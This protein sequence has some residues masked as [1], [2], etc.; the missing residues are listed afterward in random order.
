MV[1]LE[2]RSTTKRINAIFERLLRLFTKVVV[3]F[4]GTEHFQSSHL[5]EANTETLQLQAFHGPLAGFKRL[6]PSWGARGQ[7][8][9]GARPC[10]FWH[11]SLKTPRSQQQR[12]RKQTEARSQHL[13]PRNSEQPK[14]TLQMLSRN[15]ENLGNGRNKIVC[16]FKLC[17]ASWLWVNKYMA[18]V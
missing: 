14:V 4:K 2:K 18:F 6:F 12:Q 8:W 13:P 16:C 15:M 17:S 10:C 9:S 3:V 7:V 5:G 11:H 1:V